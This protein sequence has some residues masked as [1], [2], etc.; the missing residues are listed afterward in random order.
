M[1]RI[2]INRIENTELNTYGRCLYP[3]EFMIVRGENRNKDLVLLGV[4]EFNPIYTKPT[5]NAAKAIV[6]GEAR[7]DLSA[8]GYLYTIENISSLSNPL[9]NS[10]GFMFARLS[11]DTDVAL[12]PSTN[13]LACVDR[14]IIAEPTPD[15]MGYKKTDEIALVSD[16][17]GAWV[18]SV[19]QL[20]SFTTVGTVEIDLSDYLPNDNKSYLVWLIVSQYSG[21]TTQ[22]AVAFSTSLYNPNKTVGLLSRSDTPWFAVSPVIPVGSDRKLILTRS[23][24]ESQNFNCSAMG[25]RKIG[26]V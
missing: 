18:S 5:E 24:G 8:G 11:D 13:T 26:G 3:G 22:S 16:L 4:N 20:S 2:Q 23:M 14:P 21:T 19:R 7:I 25:Y 12:I 6:T 1:P 9:A 17:D 15:L 10:A